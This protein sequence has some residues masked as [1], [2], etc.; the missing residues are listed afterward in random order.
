MEI[1]LLLYFNWQ[2][3]IRKKPHTLSLGNTKKPTGTADSLKYMLFILL[4]SFW[5][6]LDKR[7]SW[8]KEERKLWLQ[9]EDDLTF[10]FTNRNETTLIPVAGTNNLSSCIP[11]LPPIYMNQ[12]SSSCWKLI[13]LCSDEMN[14]SLS[15]EFFISS[16]SIFSSGDFFPII[17]KNSKVYFS[18]EKK[19]LFIS[20]SLLSWATWQ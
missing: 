8:G 3:F 17:Y 9:H 7:K 15:K 12:I 11:F 14:H 4:F 1:I 16:I 19:I 20:M 13:L 18:K 10:Y 5:K 6:D 2:S